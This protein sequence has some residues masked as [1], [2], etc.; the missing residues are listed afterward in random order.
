MEVVELKGFRSHWIWT[1]LTYKRYGHIE[2]QS[3]V[4]VP[5]GREW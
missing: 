2:S 5:I 3:I 4:K 1:G